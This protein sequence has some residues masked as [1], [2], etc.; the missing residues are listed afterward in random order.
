MLA[1]KKGTGY[2]FTQLA[3][4]MTGINIPIFGVSW[5]PPEPQ[6]KIVRELLVFLEDR[7][8]LYNP[9]SLEVEPELV[10]SV[11]KIREALT[12]AISRLA[13]NAQ[14]V[15]WLRAMRI[16]CRTFLD[17]ERMP[18]H[19]EHSSIFLELGE[20][21]ALFGTHIAYLSVHFGIG[22]EAD[23]ASIVPNQ[24]KQDD[25]PDGWLLKGQSRKRDQG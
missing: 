24:F 16:A 17:S 12:S 11:R 19:G 5:R 20:L 13:D 2:K 14:A 23:L 25:D 10:D 1:M 7:R 21:R 4:R 3:S 9:Y 22:L 18:F 8:V 15:S 6:R